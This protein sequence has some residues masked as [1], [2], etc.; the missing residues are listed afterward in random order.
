[1]SDGYFQ[2]ALEGESEMIRTHMGKYNRSVLAA[3]YGIPCV[4]TSCDSNSG[5]ER[6][7]NPAN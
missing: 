3:V 2:R 4:M 1:M 5:L 7:G 6:G